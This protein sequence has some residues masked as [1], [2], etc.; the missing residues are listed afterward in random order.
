MPHRSPVDVR[1]LAALGFEWLLILA[2]LLTALRVSTWGGAWWVTCCAYVAAFV[3]IA[4]RQ[5]A[6]LM[7]F[8]DAVHGSLARNRS[9]NDGL[10]NALIGVPALLPVELYRPL[11]L[12]HHHALGT[13]ADP[14]RELLYAGQLWNYRP[15]ETWPLVLQLIGDLLVVNGARTMAAW[16][17]AGGSL[18]MRPT[19]LGIAT[20]WLVG[21]AALAWQSPQTAVTA[22]LLW[23]APL[24]TLTQ[25][26]QKLRSFAEH[27]GGPGVTADWDDWT[28]TWRVGPAGRLTIWPYNINLH[29][30]HHA[31][32]AVPWHELPALAKATPR[33]RASNTLWELLHRR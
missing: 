14:E 32:P 1:S 31:N 3:V 6:L 12:K 30:E 8:H 27:S 26:L 2:A 25:L 15:L 7:L 16:R 17:Q 21:I 22:L 18:R 11:H 19:T 33:F 10:I 24:L 29:L 20:L 23:F 28:Y 5:H 13:S 9:A 4:T